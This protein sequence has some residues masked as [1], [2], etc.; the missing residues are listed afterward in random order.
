M[1]LYGITDIE[2]D[3][4]LIADPHD[5]DMHFN[6]LGVHLELDEIEDTTR[7]GADRRRMRSALGLDQTNRER[8]C[9]RA[10]ASRPGAGGRRT[11]HDRR[12]IARRTD[13]IG[14]ARYA[15]D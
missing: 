7:S 5:R 10:S 12:R 4:W 6:V 13:S 15:R 9:G 1:T 8:D 2:G 3:G 14:K 11:G